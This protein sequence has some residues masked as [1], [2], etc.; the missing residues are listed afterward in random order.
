[1]S[2]FCSADLCLE[3][4]QAGSMQA[5][6]TDTSLKERI[7]ALGV[8][9]SEEPTESKEDDDSTEQKDTEMAVSAEEDSAIAK[10][11]TGN[12]HRERCN[13]STHGEH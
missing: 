4:S 13:E 10:E 9:D 5:E 3:G 7:E 12:L 2:G 6:A 8:K 11:E 1:M